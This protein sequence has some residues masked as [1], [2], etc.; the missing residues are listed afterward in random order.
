MS[1]SP[2]GGKLREP[3]ASYRLESV[4]AGNF[5]RLPLCTRIDTARQL[6]AQVVAAQG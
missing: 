5:L 4:G 1:L 3:L 6:L 2:I